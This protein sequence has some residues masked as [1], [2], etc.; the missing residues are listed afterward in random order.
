MLLVFTSIAFM[1]CDKDKPYIDCDDPDYSNCL[2]EEP[3]YW[4]LDLELTFNDENSKIPVTV[5]YGKPENNVVAFYDTISS[6]KAEY[7]MPVNVFYS[8]KAEYRKGQKIIHAFDGGYM[9]KKSYNV[10]DSVC[11]VVNDLVLDLKL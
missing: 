11:W 7:V 1:A 2:T 5:Y 8:A 6:S 9:K 3:F 4:Y 10:C